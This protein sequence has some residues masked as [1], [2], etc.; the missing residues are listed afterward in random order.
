MARGSTWCRTV[1]DITGMHHFEGLSSEGP[2]VEVEETDAGYLTL[3]HFPLVEILAD[4]VVTGQR[5]CL[6][7]RDG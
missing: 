7:Q 2:W 6:K 4:Q 3:E 1:V 5:W